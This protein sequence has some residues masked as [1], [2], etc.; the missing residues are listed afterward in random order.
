MAAGRPHPRASSSS[1]ASPGGAR[2]MAAACPPLPAPPAAALPGTGQRLAGRQ[3]LGLP[4]F[5]GRLRRAEIH[6]NN[7]LREVAKLG[8]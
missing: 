4:S 8:W 6:S 3:A 5:G 1:R 2:M 7:S